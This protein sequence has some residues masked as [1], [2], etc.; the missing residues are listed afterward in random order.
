[1]IKEIH[2]DR[3]AEEAARA[4]WLADLPYLLT[5]LV[6]HNSPVGHN[7]TVRVVAGIPVF[8]RQPGPG[9]V[10]DALVIVYHCLAL[11]TLTLAQGD[12]D[13]IEKLDASNAA[14]RSIL[15]FVPKEKF[16]SLGRNDVCPCGSGRKVKHCHGLS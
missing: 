11:L 12:T 16:V 5:N 8:S 14:H 6:L 15:V 3:P 9:L 2:V 10:R 1:M 4:E 13:K 7:A